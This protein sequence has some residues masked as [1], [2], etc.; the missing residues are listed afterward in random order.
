MLARLRRLALAGV[1]VE[2]A[3]QPVFHREQAVGALARLLLLQ[4]F[5]GRV[6]QPFHIVEAKQRRLALECVHLATQ[7]RDGGLVRP[8]LHGKDKPLHLLK[9]ALLAGQELAE[10]RFIHIGRKF[11]GEAAALLPLTVVLRRSFSGNSQL[12]RIA[13][14]GI[15]NVSALQGLEHAHRAV[16]NLEHRPGVIAFTEDDG[17]GHFR[18]FHRGRRR[19]R[20]IV[21]ARPCVY[22]E[23]RCV[24]LRKDRQVG[25]IR[26]HHQLRELLDGLF[27]AL[28]HR[29]TPPLSLSSCG[30]H[31]SDFHALH[32]L[33]LA[34]TFFTA[35]AEFYIKQGKDA[36]IFLLYGECGI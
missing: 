31:W 30:V 14:I 35:Y 12:L 23:K 8:A 18:G 27:N 36:R 28:A 22:L 5:F 6:A 9:H 13:R 7:F 10:Y 26:E 20:V 33:A 15:N 11:D 19:A 24:H 29:W 1:R 3:L 25:L 16:Q 17:L 2:S 34:I 4:V 21:F 32:I